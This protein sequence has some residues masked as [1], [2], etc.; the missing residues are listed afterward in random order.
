MKPHLRLRIASLTAC[1]LLAGAGRDR[2]E[3]SK[4][5]PP[6]ASNAAPPETPKPPPPPTS[7]HQD[8]LMGYDLLAD[9]P[10]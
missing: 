4:P 7:A 5:A 6:E 8:L 2:P 10:G 1:A 9:T 3:T